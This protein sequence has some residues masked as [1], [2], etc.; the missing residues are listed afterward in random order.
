MLTGL[1]SIL[2]RALRIVA[3]LVGGAIYEVTRL[4]PEAIRRTRLYQASLDRF[5]RVL[6]ESL[7]GARGVFPPDGLDPGALARRKTAGNAMELAGLAAVGFSPLWILAAASDV[8]GGTKAYGRALLREL[9]RD[10]LVR[11]D[12][13]F[14]S[15]GALL[16]E[17]ESTSGLA[18]ETLDLPPLNVGELRAA[19]AE[20]RANA[21]AIPEP[22][23]LAEIF[24]A[25]RRAADLQDRSLR[26]VSLMVAEGAWRAGA[27]LREAHI[28]D[29]YRQA[30]ERLADE[31]PAAYLR[32]R[33]AP[34]M[35]ALARQ[36]DPRRPAWIEGR[37]ARSRGG[38]PVV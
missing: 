4:L 30:L 11:A 3:L 20:L 26:S 14:G 9:Q 31:G 27:D 38:D 34:Y 22:R 23:R 15:V 7:G 12:A 32:R 17:L 6:I 2:E 18:A 19:L 16:D 13:D 28:Y 36:L 25:L 21:A 5:L 29:Y 1:L 37:H 33:S 24:D 8:T 10:G 35:R